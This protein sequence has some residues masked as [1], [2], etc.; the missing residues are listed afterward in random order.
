MFLWNSTKCD[1]ARECYSDIH[2][3]LATYKHP[4]QELRQR[5]KPINIQCAASTAQVA[6]ARRHKPSFLDQAVR[7]FNEEPAVQITGEVRSKASI[8]DEGG[9]APLPLL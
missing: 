9:I 4:A 8:W 5:Q 2:P 3:R 1:L 7:A 6:N